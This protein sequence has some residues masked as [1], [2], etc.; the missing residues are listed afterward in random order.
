[1][2]DFE[3][4][5]TAVRQQGDRQTC[6][7]FAVS[8]AHEWAQTGTE[9]LAPEDALW[10]AHQQ[11]PSQ[12]NGDETS[13]N[14]ALAGLDSHQHASEAAW[15]YGN[16][17]WRSGRP[18]EAD[19]LANRR[20]LPRWRRLDR[21]TIK[22]IRGELQTDRAVVLTVG[23][24]LAAW[25][26]PDGFIDAPAGQKIPGT[27]AVSVVGISEDDDH[28]RTLKIKNSWGE[29]WGQR[30]YGTM[31]GRYL[32]AYAVCAHTIERIK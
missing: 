1:M 29:R 11:M 21:T 27:H 28:E 13:V 24:V 2:I 6:V 14:Y 18:P 20:A 12:F 15:P 30:G 7:A 4:E 16:P 19:N 17:D 26:R 25:R 5:Q 9:I 32:D 23:V 8:A 31:S 22:S 10:A 3:S